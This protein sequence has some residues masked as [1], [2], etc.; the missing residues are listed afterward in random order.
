MNVRNLVKQLLL[1]NASISGKEQQG[2]DLI[3]RD[4]IEIEWVQTFRMMD[5]KMYVRNNPMIIAGLKLRKDH[6][7]SAFSD[8]AYIVAT[9]WVHESYR[10]KALGAVLYGIA[11]ELAGDDGITSDRWDVSKDAF[12]MWDYFSS[13]SRI[14][15]QQL[16]VQTMSGKTFLTPDLND[17]TVIHSTIEHMGGEGG[18]Y[19]DTYNGIDYWTSPDFKDKYLASPL[20]KKYMKPGNA[21][22]NA[23]GDRI[24]GSGSRLDNKP[25]Y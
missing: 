20:S 17:D 12:R 9:A 21:L 23:L 24:S 25:S 3:E 7:M 6:E 2:L 1:E 14:D 15:Q 19:V 13:D 10:H 16:D 22:I 11:L 5:V 18:E 4:D 8:D